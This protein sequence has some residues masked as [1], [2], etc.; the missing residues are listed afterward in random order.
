MLLRQEITGCG[1]EKAKKSNKNQIAILILGLA[2]D[3]EGGRFLAIYIGVVCTMFGLSTAERQFLIDGV[4]LNVR[5][6]GR[7]RLDF[8]H[9]T[10]ETG[11]VTT[12]NGSARLKLDN[13]DVMVGVRV[14]LAEPE[15]D[16][17]NEGA[18]DFAATRPRSV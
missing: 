2:A 5:N 15:L 12:A 11:L 1:G 3:I 7:S 17:P 18:A 6:D 10:V 13:T 8:R 4:E 9:F 14:D 16:R